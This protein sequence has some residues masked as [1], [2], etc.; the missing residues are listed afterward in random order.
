MGTACILNV[1]RCGRTHCR[2]TGPYYLAMI[3]PVGVL[4]CG[5]V[6]AGIYAWSVLAGVILLGSGL[7]WR[8]PSV[9]GANTL[10]A[11]LQAPSVPRPLLADTVL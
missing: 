8:A 2:Y 11:K 4:G 1:K 10:K 7:L 9:L 6:P 3:V 5:V